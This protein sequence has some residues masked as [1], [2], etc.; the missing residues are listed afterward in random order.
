M[1]QHLPTAIRIRRRTLDMIT[2]LNGGVTPE[3]EKK[4]TFFLIHCHGSDHED[5]EI[6]D[7]ATYGHTYEPMPV[8]VD[9]MRVTKIG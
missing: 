1:C 3:I 2:A 8:Y 6:I 9:A 5:M 7:E 4:T